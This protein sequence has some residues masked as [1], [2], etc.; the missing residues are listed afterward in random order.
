MMK[1]IVCLIQVMINMLSF[2]F[3]STT[4][5]AIFFLLI[6]NTFAQEIGGWYSAGLDYKISKKLSFGSNIE[7]RM[8]YNNGVNL[9]QYFPEVKLS[10]KIKKY[11]ALSGSYR[12]SQTKE[13]NGYF[14]SRNKFY[15][16]ISINKDIKRFTVKNRLRYQYQKKQYINNEYD[17]IPDKYLRNKFEVS[18]NIKKNPIDPF[19]S[20]EVYYPL[21]SFEINTINEYRIT[22]GI[23]FP[24][25]KKNDMSIGLMYN[26]ERFSAPK[27]SYNLLVSYEFS[28]K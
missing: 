1:P 4:L 7:A 27:A 8:N 9:E 23:D 11:I 13:D 28:V 3:K 6:T 14:Y 26:Q 20:F 5:V 17:K 19:L 2:K 24:L 25:N 16:N 18:Y 22:G 15:A 12:F 10:Y 21:N